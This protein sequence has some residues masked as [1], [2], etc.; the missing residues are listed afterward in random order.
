MVH[1]HSTVPSL[2]TSPNAAPRDAC[3][4][5]SAGPAVQKV[6]KPSIPKILIEHMPILIANVYAEPVDFGIGVAVDQQKVFPAVIVEIKEAATPANKTSVVSQSGALRSI[7]K[8]AVA[9]IAIQS[10]AFVGKVAAKQVRGHPRRSRLPLPPCRKA[11]G[12]SRQCDAT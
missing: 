7:V 10:F 11:P 8:L 3:R 4:S 1:K 6:R 9:A 12:R 2:S 5:S